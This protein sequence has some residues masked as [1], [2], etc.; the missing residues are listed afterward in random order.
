MLISDTEGPTVHPVK[1]F[2]MVEANIND[3]VDF[4]YTRFLQ[5]NFMIIVVI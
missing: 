4:S 5:V 3:I 2:D 1:F